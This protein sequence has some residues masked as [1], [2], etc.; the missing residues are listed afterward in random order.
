MTKLCGIIKATNNNGLTQDR[1]QAMN[2]VMKHD[3]KAREEQVHFNNGGIAVIKNAKID[4]SHLYW[5]ERHTCC[6]VSC[7]H[8]VN[9]ETTNGNSAQFLLNGYEEQ[10]EG[11]LKQVNGV[12]A[13][14]HVDVETGIVTIG[15]DR[16]GYMPLY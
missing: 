12:F 3:P 15:H 13:F 6:L 9:T 2:R 4:T 11:F 16:Y 8:I 1:L 14:A 10:G 7:G 5:N